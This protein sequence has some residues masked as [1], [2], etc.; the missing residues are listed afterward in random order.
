MTTESTDY[1][2]LRLRLRVC[3]LTLEVDLGL[4]KWN[5]NPQYSYFHLPSA[6]ESA[7]MPD[8]GHMPDCALMPDSGVICN[9]TSII[10]MTVVKSIRT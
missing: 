10:C 3:L 6:C 2:M 9:A 4:E 7:L 8:S 1:C 5:C